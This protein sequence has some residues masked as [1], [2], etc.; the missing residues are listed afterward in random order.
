MSES[1]PAGI[2]TVAALQ[3]KPLAGEGAG[4]GSVMRAGA[5]LAAGAPAGS[6]ADGSSAARPQVVYL[7][8]RDTYTS[9]VYQTDHCYL[10]LDPFSPDDVAAA[11]DKAAQLRAAAQPV[12]LALRCDGSLYILHADKIACIESVGRKVRVTCTDGKQLEAYAT[13]ADIERQL[14]TA[15]VRCHKRYLVNLDCVVRLDGA[16]LLL[17]TGDVVSV[18]QRRLPEVREILANR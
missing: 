11:L 9:D 16:E 15:L 7:A 1:V 4:A 8:T 10:L 17:T 12:T 13:L 2:R 6:G 3:G 14:S 18:S 5:G